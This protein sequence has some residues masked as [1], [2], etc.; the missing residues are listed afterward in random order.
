MVYLPG[1]EQLLESQLHRLH[2]IEIEPQTFW[3]N[4]DAGCDSFSFDLEQARLVQ[5]YPVAKTFHSVGFPIGGTSSTPVIDLQ[6]LSRHASLIHPAWISEHLSFN[7]FEED[8]RLLNTNFLLPPL[9]TEE[10]VRI[11]V[12]NINYFRSVV[13]LPFAFET[14]VNYLAP[15]AGE[16]SDGEFVARIATRSD[17]CILLDLHNILTN[18]KNGRQSVDRFIGQLP[19]ERVCEIHIAGGFHFRNYYIDAHAGIASDELFDLLDSIVRRLPALKAVIFEMLPEYADN[20]S[21]DQLGAQLERMHRIWDNRGKDLRVT[22]RQ[23]SKEDHQ[24][25][26]TQLWTA[27][28]WQR[29][30]GNAVLGRPLMDSRLSLELAGDPGVGIIAELIFHFR[31]AALTS[32]LNYTTRLLRLALGKEAFHEMLQQFLAGTDPEIF[33]FASAVK[34]ASFLREKNYP[35]AYLKKTLEFELTT[36]YILLDNKSRSVEFNFNPFPVMRSLS[37]NTLPGEQDAEMSFI[38]DIQPDDQVLN[39]DVLNFYS[40]YHN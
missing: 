5:Q 26:G 29:D 14:G 9:P 36:L 31:T 11:A 22:P 34:F 35:V 23:L 21:S 4:K 32:A 25:Q 8:G 18:Q 7:N 12:D 20:V 38:L 30:L 28:Q 39:K 40:V 17:S 10:G 37:E 15:R 33:A 27:K 24:Q 3:H 19:L 2:A 16:I 6:L 13:D 1:L